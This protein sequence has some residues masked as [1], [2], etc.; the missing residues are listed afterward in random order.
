MRSTKDFWV[1]R[2]HI[3]NDYTIRTFIQMNLKVPN[4]AVVP[5][6]LVAISSKTSISRESKRTQLAVYYLILIVEG[7]NILDNNFDFSYQKTPVCL[8]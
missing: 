8:E 6:L 5:I 2:Y 3:T 7:E 4:P 1:N